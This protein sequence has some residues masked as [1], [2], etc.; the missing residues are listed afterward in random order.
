M[1]EIAQPPPVLYA[2]RTIET[3]DRLAV[4]VVGG[5]VKPKVVMVASVVLVVLGV[6]KVD[7]HNS[8]VPL[9]AVVVPD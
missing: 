9:V 1:R 5:V 3:H 7:K 2:E 4:A 8:V 6:G